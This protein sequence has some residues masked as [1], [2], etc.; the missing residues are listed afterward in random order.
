MEIIINDMFLKMFLYTS[1]YT[2]GPGMR[3][4]QVINCATKHATVLAVNLR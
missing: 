3:N 2:G 1:G 4:I